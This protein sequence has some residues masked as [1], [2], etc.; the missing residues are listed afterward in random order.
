[1][2]HYVLLDD[3]PFRSQSTQHVI[4]E[5]LKIYPNT[6][7]VYDATRLKSVGCILAGLLKENQSCKDRIMLG[8][9][10]IYTI[11]FYTLKMNQ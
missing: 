11:K 6:N 2:F 10:D 4:E 8:H 7:A 1:M 5:D 9:R 3:G